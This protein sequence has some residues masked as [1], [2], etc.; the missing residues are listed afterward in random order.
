MSFKKVLITIF[1]ICM[2][3]SLFGGFTIFAMHIIGLIIGA[4]HGA[5]IMTFASSEISD[6][7]IQVSS[8]GIVVGLIL[9]YLTDTHTLTYHSEKK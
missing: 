2:A 5:A 4:E 3:I 1:A 8:I 9:L 7:L 6:L